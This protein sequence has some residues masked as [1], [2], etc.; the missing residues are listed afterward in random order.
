MYTALARF[1]YGIAKA[2]APSNV[3]KILKPA[4]DL[5]TKSALK[6][7][8]YASGEEKLIRGIKGA[9][10]KGMS[11]YEKLYGATLGTE[12]RR[13]VTSGVLGGYALGSFLNGD[14]QDEE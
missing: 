4:Y 10:Q 1:G 5:A 7:T 6:G 11:G 12:T 8:K 2:L 9:A 13:K 14:D 3:K